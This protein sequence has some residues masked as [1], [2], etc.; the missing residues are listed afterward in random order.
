MNRY[1]VDLFILVILLLVSGVVSLSTL[2]DK[3]AAADD[4]DHANISLNI[5]N[6]TLQSNI[7]DSNNAS[8]NNTFV[9]KNNFFLEV[10]YYFTVEKKDEIIKVLKYIGYAVAGLVGLILIFCCCPCCCNRFG[11]GGDGIKGG[12]GAACCQSCLGNVARGSCFSCLQSA[13]ARG[14]F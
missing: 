14:Y 11:F 7:N 4:T 1:K 9:E 5:E 8:S 10:K 6:L 12:S 3:S 13:G 2:S